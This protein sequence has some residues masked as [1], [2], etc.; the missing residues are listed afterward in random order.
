MTEPRIDAF[1]RLLA[2]GTSRRRLI[3]C[4]G[5]GA[6]AITGVMAFSQPALVCQRVATACDETHACCAGATCQGRQCVCQQ[7]REAC[8]GRG[9]CVDTEA[10]NDHCGRCGNPCADGETCCAGRCVSAKRDRTNCGACGTVC[11]NN[12]LCV[13]GS[14][15]ACPLGTVPCGTVCRAPARCRDS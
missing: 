12:E 14:C 11:G 8:D 4:L 5:G 10:D 13:L 15:L 6:V 2:H 7:G 3:S 9:L 1:A